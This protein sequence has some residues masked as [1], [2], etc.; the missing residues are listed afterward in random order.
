MLTVV[1]ILMRG[2]F[3]RLLPP[4]IAVLDASDPAGVVLVGLEGALG[5]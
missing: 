4:L 1:A 3:D 5:G 2:R